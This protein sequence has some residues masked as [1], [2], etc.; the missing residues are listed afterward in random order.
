MEERIEPVSADWARPTRS[1]VTVP[2]RRL[3]SVVPFKLRFAVLT[4][5]APEYRVRT[6]VAF[7]RRP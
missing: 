7:A 4:M 3:W 6:F 5:L 1:I 2:L